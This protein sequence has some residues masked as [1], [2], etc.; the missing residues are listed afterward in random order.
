MVSMGVTELKPSCPSPV[1][2]DRQCEYETGQYILDVNGCLR[3]ICPTRSR[4][5]DV[6]KILI[7]FI[8]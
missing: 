6:S 2:H 5:C 7:L 1:I 3:K 4:L 8:N